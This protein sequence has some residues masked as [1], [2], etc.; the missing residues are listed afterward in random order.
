[1]QIRYSVGENDCGHIFKGGGEEV[2]L[3]GRIWN[4]GEKGKEGGK[5]GGY[6]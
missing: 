4:K 6:I 3:V 5:G 2:S 1:M